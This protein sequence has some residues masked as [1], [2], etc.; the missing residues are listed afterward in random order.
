MYI[1]G[2]SLH[3]YIPQV[4]NNESPIKFLILSDRVVVARLKKETLEEQLRALPSTIYLNRWMKGKINDELLIRY[5]LDSFGVTSSVPFYSL[6]FFLP[7]IYSVPFNRV[8][9][10]INCLISIL[11]GVYSWTSTRGS[12]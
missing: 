10:P 12:A 11:Q 3:V 8:P 7:C 9:F 5:E 2:S 1:F 6:T 4:M